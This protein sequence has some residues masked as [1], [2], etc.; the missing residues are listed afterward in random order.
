MKKFKQ[1]LLLLIPLALLIFSSSYNTIAEKTSS[2][3]TTSLH[4]EL[5]SSGKLKE[6]S[7]EENILK[8]DIA[9][10]QKI[11]FQIDN[12]NILKSMNLSSND[13]N[14]FAQISN[15]I[16]SKVKFE[17]EFKDGSIM[18]YHV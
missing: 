6:I 8:S 4:D 16:D 5:L 13:I 9:V 14:S 11:N 15:S 12:N 1:L 18:N 3:N 10:T 7:S 2:N 17:S